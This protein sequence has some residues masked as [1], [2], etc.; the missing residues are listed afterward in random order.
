MSLIPDIYGEI[1]RSERFQEISG[2]ILAPNRFLP[3]G[4]EKKNVKFFAQQA[5]RK[6]CLSQKFRKIQITEIF[7]SLLPRKILAVLEI[8]KSITGNFSSIASLFMPPPASLQKFF[9]KS[10]DY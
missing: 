2:N 7:C 3:V 1:F 4:Q 9:Q 8:L 10:A 5:T 6:F